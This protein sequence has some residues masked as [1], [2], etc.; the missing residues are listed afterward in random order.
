MSA[1]GLAGTDWSAGKSTTEK[2]KESLGWK[3][4]PVGELGRVR[5]PGAVKMVIW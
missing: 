5:P 4:L 2:S 1:A 3:P